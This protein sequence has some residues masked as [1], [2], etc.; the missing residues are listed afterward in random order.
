MSVE[1]SVEYR[2]SFDGV[3]IQDITGHSTMDTTSTNDQI[4]GLLRAKNCKKSVIAHLSV[5]HKS[6][7]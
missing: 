7:N 2:L 1:M 4:T 3:L 5:S 6:N